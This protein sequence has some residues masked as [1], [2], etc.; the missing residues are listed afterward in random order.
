MT[1]AASSAWKQHWCIVVDDDQAPG[2][3]M[4]SDI[5]R[6]PVQYCRLDKESTPLQRALHRASSIA[7]ASQVLLTT[8]EEF[9]DCWE[10]AAWFIRP[11]R[12]FIGDSR[13]ASHLSC[14]AAMLAVAAKSPSSVV[15]IMPARCYVAD[16]RI[17]KQALCQT[18]M[19]LPAIPE[20]VATLGMLDIHDGVDENYL[21]VSAPR[22]GRGLQI[23]GYARRP[24]PWVA[25]YLKSHGALMASGILVGYA[26]AFAEHISRTWPGIS[27]QLAKLADT[28]EI[29][30]EECDVPSSLNRRVPPSVLRALRWHPPAFRQRVVSV[31]RCGWSGLHSPQSV[32][33]I[34]TF[35]SRESRLAHPA[36]LDPSYALSCPIR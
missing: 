24:V 9:R 6:L 4:G 27:T 20:G 31:A 18:Y 26:A 2:W 10:P 21:L 8:L 3:T 7:P 14:A 33:Q 35:L 23:D 5:E 36:P 34:I 12:R 30:G 19:E 11:W 32:T 13:W 29:A 15:T 17:L 22:I 25:R 1:P 28:A 16:E